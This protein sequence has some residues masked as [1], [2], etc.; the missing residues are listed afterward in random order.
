MGSLKGAF[1]SLNTCVGMMKDP[2][3][4]LL[5]VALISIS[6]FSLVVG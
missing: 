6:I 4:L 5:F 3:D 1:N 2:E